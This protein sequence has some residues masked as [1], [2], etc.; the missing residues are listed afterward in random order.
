[1]PGIQESYKPGNN[2][3]IEIAT[4]RRDMQ[5]VSK[6]IGRIDESFQLVVE[7]GKVIAVQQEKMD[8]LDKRLSDQSQDLRQFKNRIEIDIEALR[9]SS[10][11]E[12][13]Q[14]HKELIDR[15]DFYAGETKKTLED[16]AKT[17]ESQAATVSSQG[18]ILDT[19]NRWF[20]NVIAVGAAIMVVIGLLPAFE[21]ISSYLF[22]K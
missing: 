4:L 19:H 2:L 13:L 10:H 7:Q 22:P 18:R 15:I 20:Y 5:Y 17:M 9:T 14:H 6:I 1:M 12:R 8:A 3:E 21:S 16:H 11:N